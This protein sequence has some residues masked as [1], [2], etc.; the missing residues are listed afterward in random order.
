LLLLLLYQNLGWCVVA[1]LEV[2]LVYAAELAVEVDVI[3]ACPALAV[4]ADIVN[5]REEV[6][7][8]MGN[9]KEEDNTLQAVVDEADA[10]KA[11]TDEADAD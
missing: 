5:D 4:V 11:T 1:F 3:V 6:E 10:N 8:C 2:A 9:M 7:D